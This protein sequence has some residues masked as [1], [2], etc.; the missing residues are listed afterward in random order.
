MTS[1]VQNAIKHVPRFRG[2]SILPKD[3]KFSPVFNKFIFIHFQNPI[4]FPKLLK[5]INQIDFTDDFLFSFMT[6]KEEDNY[7]VFTNKNYF[8]LFDLKIFHV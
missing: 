2:D 8:V 6:T 5:E 7:F 1:F 3:F 4:F